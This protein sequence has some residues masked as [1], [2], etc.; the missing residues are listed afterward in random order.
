[1]LDIYL[2]YLKNFNYNI[3]IYNI[4]PILFELAYNILEKNEIFSIEFLE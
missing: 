3:I 2:N 4:T 1:M